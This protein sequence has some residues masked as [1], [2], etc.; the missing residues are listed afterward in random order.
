LATPA[1]TRFI[2]DANTRATATFIWRFHV[3]PFNPEQFIMRP[4]LEF[5]LK[6]RTRPSLIYE[7]CKTSYL[8]GK[9]LQ[10]LWSYWQKMVE[11][12]ISTIFTIQMLL[13][14]YL[15]LS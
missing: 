1:L 12:N 15:Q 13:I 7:P 4:I 10:S 11:L 2:N 3:S 8:I 6:Q 14:A 5:L 9:T